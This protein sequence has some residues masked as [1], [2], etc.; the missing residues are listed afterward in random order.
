MRHLLFSL[1]LFLSVSTF[2][3]TNVSLKGSIVLQSGGKIDSYETYLLSPTDSLVVFMNVFFEKEFFFKNID[4]GSYI[5][6]INSIQCQPYDTLITIFGGNNIIL[7]DIALKDNELSEALVIGRKPLVSYNNGN[8]TFNVADSYLKDENNINAILEKIPSIMVDY[9]G[10][11]SIFGKNNLVIYINEREVKDQ[12]QVKSLQPSDIEKIELVRNVG[13]EYS[14]SV[15]AVLKIRTKRRY[16]EKMSIV[17]TNNTYIN[18]NISNDINIGISFNNGKLSHYLSYYN[19]LTKGE[20]HDDNITQ[21]FFDHYSGINKRAVDMVNKYRTNTIFYSLNYSMNS[22][23]ELGFQYSG[24]FSTWDSHDDGIQEI[25]HDKFVVKKKKF[26]N[27]EII[28]KNFHN[29]SLN[30]KHDFDENKALTIIGDYTVPAINV[31]NNVVEFDD[32][33]QNIINNQTSSKF[34][35]ASVNTEFKSDHKK[36]GY[37]FG[38]KYSYISNNAIFESSNSQNTNHLLYENIGALYASGKADLGCINVRSGIRLEYANSDI[39][40][41]TGLNRN[42]FNF[43]PYVSISKSFGKNVNATL[44]YRRTIKRPSF[45]NLN[46]QFIY[47][48]SLT[49]VTGNPFLQPMFADRI[50]LNVSVSKFN[51]SVNYNTYHNMFFIENKQYADNNSITVSTYGNMSEKYRLL[52]SSLSYTIDHSLFSSIISIDLSKPYLSWPFDNGTIRMNKPIVL[53]KTSGNIYFTK[54]TRFNYSFVF[55]SGG[56]EDNMRRKSYSNLSF[57]VSQYFL[58]KKMMLSLSINDLFDRKKSNRW[59]S[60]NNNILYTMDS[61]PNTRMLIVT[62]RYNWGMAKG[63]SQKKSSNTEDMNRL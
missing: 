12:A 10:V 61:N 8:L 15:D 14:A 31:E 37:N 47:R 17:L 33:S 2:S 57:S 55:E 29:F 3:Q 41:Q 51:I 40:S 21:T 53:I 19:D 60:F 16:D 24:N 4:T 39:R 13:A 59:T 35:M 26:D 11:I 6:K 23:N 25:L 54:S 42:Y 7:P 63:N 22:G 28:D 38:I 46:P 58:E 27:N 30:Y 52:T 18:K 9:N 44:F 49:Y 48:D 43:F 20:Q 1:L 50:S 34:E 45:S 62:L 5:L 36:I 32:N 56:D